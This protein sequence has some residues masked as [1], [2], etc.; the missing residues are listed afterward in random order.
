MKLGN[1]GWGSRG[2]D[3]RGEGRREGV[4]GLPRG[5]YLLPTTM[6]ITR[7]MVI[8]MMMCG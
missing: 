3:L 6:V 4:K 1:G 8:M 7:M 2:V 5:I